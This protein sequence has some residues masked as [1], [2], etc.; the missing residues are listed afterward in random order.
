MSI[1]K[2]EA[3]RGG[4]L[5]RSLAA[6]GI[7]KALAEQADPQAT[8]R[9]IGADMEI[10]STIDDIAEWIA[11][12]YR[13]MPVL[14][15]W[16]EGS[17]FG[18]KDVNPKAR[19]EAIKAAG[20]PRF[21]DFLEAYALCEPMAARFREKR[22]P[23]EEQ[24]Q[25]YRNAVPDRMV[26]W[27][28]TAVIVLG[29]DK[30]AFPPILGSGG[31]DGRLEFSTQYHE[32]IAT[33]ISYDPKRHASSLQ[34]ARQLIVNDR[35]R[36]EKN[37]PGQFDPGGAR[38]P[39]SSPTGAASALLNTWEYVMMMEG[40]TLFASAPARKMSASS[41]QFVS[42]TRASTQAAMTFSTFGSDLGTQ[43]GT[44]VED[45]RGDIWIPSWTHRLR[46]RIV[47][48]LFRAGRAVWRDRT[49]IRTPDMYCAVR[50]GGTAEGFNTFDRYSFLKRNGRSYSAIRTDS[51][52]ARTG[53]ALL[54]IAESVEDWPRQAARGT[55]LPATITRLTHHFETARLRVATDTGRGQIDAV[56]D[57]LAAVTR[58]EIAV[59]RS[60]RTRENCP[61]RPISRKNP[62][63]ELLRDNEAVRDQLDADPAF[64]IAV[65]LA[66]VRT[67]ADAT[68]PRGRS[69]REIL[70]P[71]APRP[72]AR[73][74]TDSPLVSGLGSRPLTAVLADVLQWYVLTMEGAKSLDH[75][76]PWIG[77]KGP[78]SGI[79]VSCSDL[80]RWVATAYLDPAVGK[81]LLAL[82]ALDWRAD[83]N[84][85]AAV[86]EHGSGALDP[87]FA[88]LAYLR[89]G[90]SPGHRG[91]SDRLSSETTGFALTTEIVGALIADRPGAAIELTRRRLR[92]VGLG[93]A[94]PHRM[95]GA[96]SKDG[97]RLAA[98][99]LPTSFLGSSAAHQVTYPLRPAES[100]N[101]HDPV[102][103]TA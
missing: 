18:A 3:A 30:L 71:V 66:S 11:D 58:T 88:L 61:P 17:G 80:D 72:A 100:D 47:E 21:A 25:R 64:R 75:V 16:N 39:N 22:V 36:L 23:K 53:N 26:S 35:S 95:M 48:Q 32:A 15:P 13:P 69:L 67:G 98:A 82:L 68:A 51:V 14:N 102:T 49:A 33:L 7:F 77:V 83:D 92:Q 78:Q 38:T 8:A 74:W 55:E 91:G 46:F 44:A 70:L 28:D 54:R 93:T 96:N 97:K 103:P 60:S 57:M 6:L 37:T 42:S 89:N 90:A 9:F 84:T 52:H 2:I 20:D 50:S 40:A 27:I 34:L 4:S 76:G 12:E 85:D 1:T 81:W 31:N 63:V 94:D 10:D 73:A 56:R 19:I 29:D 43:T 41:P 5:M 99:L 86:H 65:G 87:R 62:L 59:S 79:R 24:V 45:S 101:N